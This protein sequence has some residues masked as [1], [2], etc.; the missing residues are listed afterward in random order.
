MKYI[1][2]LLLAFSIYSRIPVPQLLW[3]ERDMRYTLCFFPFVGAVIGGLE[4]CWM[5][6]CGAAGIGNLCRCLILAAIPLA[7]TGGF[8]MDG[9]MD[10]MDA[11]HSY[12]KREEK[13]QILKDS[14]VGAFA[15]LM[16]ALYLLVNI[17]C[18]SEIKNPRIFSV[19][20]MGFILSRILSGLGVVC[21]PSAKTDGMLAHFADAADKKRVKII[22]TLELLL[23]VG[24]MLLLYVPAGIFLPAA[25]FL[26]SAYYVR[27]TKK[28]LGG[29]TGDTAGYFVTMCEGVLALAA[30]ILGGV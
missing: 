1:R 6:L 8:H 26:W 24:G 20:C 19:F 9:F 7:V 27:K 10:T 14:H 21:L 30:A 28:E 2:S 3:E 17:A 18:L 16:L 11:F 22:L 25:A 15:V 29:V 4:W 12:R 5:R 13:L 23:C